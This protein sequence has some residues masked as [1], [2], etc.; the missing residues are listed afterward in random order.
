[1]R[2]W[3]TPIGVLCLAAVSAAV[4]ASLLPM[5]VH[6]RFA[7]LDIG[8]SDIECDALLQK[9]RNLH[10]RNTL[11]SL[12]KYDGSDDPNKSIVVEAYHFSGEE[13]TVILLTFKDRLLA[14]KQKFVSSAPIDIDKLAVSSAESWLAPEDLARL[15]HE[16]E[17]A[18]RL[19]KSAGT[20]S[21]VVTRR[22]KPI[23]SAN[24]VVVGCRAEDWTDAKG[25]FRMLEN[26]RSVELLVGTYRVKVT[27]EGVPAKY[28]SVDSPLK[29]TIQK[30]ANLVELTLED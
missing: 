28:G 8:M 22:G 2:R 6:K 14:N 11:G 30:G 26:G 12:Y 25:E 1:M 7:K 13:H 3:L 17:E 20:L 16:R 4:I 29:V 24:V 18:E 15:L 23:K 19:R 27:G 10:H 21:G 5:D 9:D